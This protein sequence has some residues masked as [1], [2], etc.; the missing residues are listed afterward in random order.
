MLEVV[1][2][3]GR[4]GQSAGSL[5]RAEAPNKKPLR[6]AA[7]GHRRGDEDGREVLKEGISYLRIWRPML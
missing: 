1:K 4:G 6:Q 5:L 3:M 2:S 7:G